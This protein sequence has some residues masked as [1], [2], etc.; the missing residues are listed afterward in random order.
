VRYSLA[1]KRCPA[2]TVR[3]LVIN[4]LVVIFYCTVLHLHAVCVMVV[5]AAY[6]ALLLLDLSL[7]ALVYR[8][9]WKIFFPA[10]SN[11]K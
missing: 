4:Y 9:D 11:T 3:V 2:L 8:E 1:R 7:E 5:G 6:A 10:S